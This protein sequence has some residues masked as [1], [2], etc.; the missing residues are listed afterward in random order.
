[1]VL[2]WIAQLSMVL[3]CI[4]YFTHMH[5]ALLAFFHHM[6]TYN[7]IFYLLIMYPYRG[8]N[9]SVYVRMRVCVRV[10]VCACKCASVCVHVCECMCVRG[11][12]YVCVCARACARVFMRMCIYT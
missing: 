11:C 3:H 2:P 7:R 6:Q 9:K 12:M 5:V 8:G 4:V 1:M 10:C